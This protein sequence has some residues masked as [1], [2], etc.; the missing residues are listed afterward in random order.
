MLLAQTEGGDKTVD[1]LSY[2]VTAASKISIIARC[3]TGEG[4]AARVEQLKL[5][6]RLLDF[7][8]QR[9]VANALQHLAQD[10]VGQSQALAVDFS[11][12]PLS[13]G[14][15]NALKVIDPDRRVDDDHGSLR[16]ATNAGRVQITLPDDFPS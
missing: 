14:I 7:S 8:Y 3:L 9:V 10:N 4:A 13:L 11:I 6:Q 15:T 1:G 16:Q 12:Q 2:G 5:R